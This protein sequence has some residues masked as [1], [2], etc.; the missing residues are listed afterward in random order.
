MS[1]DVEVVNAGHFD[2]DLDTIN[3]INNL[4]DLK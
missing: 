1:F 4:N 2:D 3:Y